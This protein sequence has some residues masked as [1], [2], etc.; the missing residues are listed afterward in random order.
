[1]NEYKSNH[2]RGVRE[3]TSFVTLF[4]LVIFFISYIEASLFS[5]VGFIVVIFTIAMGCSMLWVTHNIMD[6]APFI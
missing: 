3:F 5:L 1:M 6:H 4:G 2:Y